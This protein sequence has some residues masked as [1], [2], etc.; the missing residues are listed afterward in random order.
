MRGGARWPHA[1]R[2]ASGSAADAVGLFAEGKP[3][4]AAFSREAHGQPLLAAVRL[5]DDQ[6]PGV[7]LPARRVVAARMRAI[8]EI[9]VLA[10]EEHAVRLEAE[11]DGLEAD[12]RAALVTPRGGHKGG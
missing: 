9:G 11:P 4:V 8:G 7:D 12:P 10:E 6:E 1:R 2:T 3:R 5:M